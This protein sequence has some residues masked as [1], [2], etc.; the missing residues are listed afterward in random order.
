MACGLAADCFAWILYNV[1]TLYCWKNNS[2]PV[3]IS[4]RKLQTANKYW[5]W[6]SRPL[7]NMQLT[8][9]SAS[10]AEGIENAVW[11]ILHTRVLSTT[12]SLA[13][14]HFEQWY[15]YRGELQWRMWLAR[16]TISCVAIRSCR[17]RAE[18]ENKFTSGQRW[19]S[20]KCVPG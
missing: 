4:T 13:A 12:G 14:D 20:L 9:Q 3:N 10:V 19:P 7:K 17:R 5:G 6:L 15:E 16:F 8:F 2:E 1:W 11:Q 18:Q